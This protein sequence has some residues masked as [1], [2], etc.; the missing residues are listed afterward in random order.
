[1]EPVSFRLN[2][3]GGQENGQVFESTKPEI[4]MGR[5]ATADILVTSAG[6]SRLH[7]RVILHE[8]YYYVEDM[9]S[10]NGTYVNGAPITQPTL[11]KTGDEIGLGQSVSLTFYSP[12]KATVQSAAVQQAQ[13]AAPVERGATVIGDD[14]YVPP[15]S[16]RAPAPQFSIA[17][18]GTDPVVYTLT[19]DILTI[20]RAE[21]NDI[22][23]G[24][25][26]VSRHHAQLQR[27]G[28]GYEIVQSPEAG[29][30]I[31]FEGRPL[32][33]PRPL[34]HEDKLR[35]GSL[36]PG[37]MVTM[38]YSAPAQAGSAAGV[39]AINFGGTQA[40][41]TI[42]RDPTNDVILDVPTV[43]H[44]H[45]QIERVG[46]RYRIRDQG[47]SNGTFVN[48]QR[49]NSNVW[50][51]PSDTIRI[52]PYRFVV[53]ENQIAQ[54]DESGGLRV[55]AIGLNKWVRKDLN[56]LQ[57]IS[58]VFQPREF[59][60]V[61][62][63]SG[64][65]KSTLVDAIAGYRPAS[66]GK[67]F[68]N[69][70]DVYRNFDAIRHNIGFVP[71][72]DI[73]HM[74]LTVYQALDYAAQLRM[75]KDTTKAERHQRIM[76]V[77]DDLDL[78]HRKDVQISGLSGGQ[79]KR[80]S[81]GVELLTKPGLFFLDEPTSGLDPGTETALM[82]LMRRLADQGRTIVLITHA[83]KNV[84]LADKV[85]FLARGGYLAWFGPP[86]EALKYFDQYRS[87][88]DR[89]AK[90]IEFDDIY[91]ILDEST[92]G[93]PADWAQRYQSNPAY[94]NYVVQPLES[95]NAD[96]SASPSKAQKANTRQQ[97]R[98]QVS[99]LRQ[100]FILS[101]RNIRI[102]TRDRFSLI[103]MLA[104]APLVGLLDFV[105]AGAMGSNPYDF[106]AGNPRAVMITSF[107]LPVYAVMVGAL[108]TMREIVKEQDVYK[109]ERLVNLKIMPYIMSKV[110]VAV[111]LGLYQASCYVVI[112]YLAFKMPG[113]VE[114][115]VL[116]YITMALATVSGMMLGLFASALA[117]NANSAPL[118]VILLLI[119]Q[120]VLGGALVPLP[121]LPSMPTATRW[122]FQA[123]MGIGGAGTDV[124]ADACW[125][126]PDSQRAALTAEQKEDPSCPCMGA[127]MLEPGVCSFPSIGR[128]RTAAMDAPEPV[129][130]PEL[131]P[132]PAEPTLPPEPERPAN[133]SD[134]IAMA[135]YADA[136]EVWRGEVEDITDQYRADVD[137]YRLEAQIYQTQMV[138]YQT[139]L[140]EWR[141]A[142]SQPIGLA[143]ANIGAFRKD[144]GWTF[145][146][147]RDP[148]N[149]IMRLSFAW[150]AEFMLA[151]VM[152][153]AILLLQKRKDVI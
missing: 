113:G 2:A 130:P 77:M 141:F 145:I 69:G 46:T 100:F 122:A 64:G 80:V 153:I 6:V 48:D 136:M 14:A 109:R 118:I 54:Y 45:A 5:D 43:S 53:G 76:E 70:V 126:L 98:Q 71:Q 152:L 36:D 97:K 106:M 55:E 29:N 146:N 20:G 149:Y 78:A 110:W 85:I 119:P 15:S 75:P 142:R 47:S 148:V 86:E 27:R 84:M 82:Q 39:S 107:L 129:A 150:G 147:K 40:L 28:D 18:A 112:R 23:I 16:G 90:D 17:V 96:L 87:D 137:A 89:R 121:G 101:A 133:E 123:I 1:V 108:A 3:P 11:L 117:P 51:G 127:T 31:L 33:E 105:I 124:D 79:L 104:A 41:I 120:I 81:I 99:A 30:P 114:E 116:I 12:Q 52:G 13:V 135:E 56:I 134:Q 143:E 144:F 62:G 94:Y 19:K 66:H 73:I 74:E 131:R 140:G 115:F 44:F 92:L 42:G 72:K 24:S 7:A 93:S 50:V 60:V 9:G 83:T 38:S 132:E 49:I 128:F 21:D 4:V 57:N 103:L 102:L 88:R 58:A 63:Q 35:I 139:K 91:A 26:I 32:M 95:R 59:I 138:D 8:G 65:G 25:K 68:V 34:R 37:S 61:V 67:V 151:L 111:L 22:V 10:S 125:A